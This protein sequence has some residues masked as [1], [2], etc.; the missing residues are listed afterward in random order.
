MLRKA[1][2]QNQKKLDS[3]NKE[4][5]DIFSTIKSF[6]KNIE[7]AKTK[8]KSL[9]EDI[10]ICEFVESELL[11]LPDAPK[12]NTNKQNEI[13]KLLTEVLGLL[14]EKQEGKTVNQN[15]L[16]LLGMAKQLLESA[17]PPESHSSIPV[18]NSDAEFSAESFFDEITKSSAQKENK[19]VEKEDSAHTVATPIPDMNDFISSLFSTVHK[20]LGPETTSDKDST[21]TAI[22]NT[23]DAGGSAQ[24]VREIVM[25]SKLQSFS[26]NLNIQPENPFNNLMNSVVG[27]VL[28]N[29]DIVK[30]LANIISNP[31]VLSSVTQIPPFRPP[32]P[33]KREPSEVHAI[34]SDDDDEVLS[35][36]SGEEDEIV[37][38]AEMGNDQE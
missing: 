35:V 34:S 33:E 13:P 10:N 9:E 24:D 31:E 38:D 23:I 29:Q 6:E 36:L 8:L 12:Q 3:L 17:Q 19:S 21:N 18:S 7:D 14:E 1:L 25:L 28:N 16:P 11:R 32:S 37:G 26:E 20:H 22:K 27:A 30:G 5:D 15:I 2:I 4:K